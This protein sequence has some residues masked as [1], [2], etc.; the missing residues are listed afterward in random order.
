MVN[1][2]CIP[3]CQS[4]IHQAS[5]PTSQRFL[6]DSTTDLARP[7]AY[8]S[9]RLL[10]ALTFRSGR[11]SSVSALLLV[12]RKDVVRLLTD[13]IIVIVI[14]GIIRLLIGM[15]IC[16][17]FSASLIIFLFSPACQTLVPGRLPKKRILTALTIFGALKVPAMTTSS[18]V[19]F[20]LS[21]LIFRCVW[22]RSPCHCGSHSSETMRSRVSRHRSQNWDILQLLSGDK[23]VKDAEFGLHQVLSET[24]LPGIPTDV[25]LLTKV[26]VDLPLL[27][28]FDNLIRRVAANVSVLARRLLLLA[29]RL[30]AI[31]RAVWVV[32][33]L[34][35]LPLS[36]MVVL[37]CLRCFS[38]S[39]SSSLSIL[40]CQGNSRASACLRMFF[41][42]VLLNSLRGM[43]R[44]RSGYGGV[45][46]GGGGGSG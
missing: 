43:G 1:T 21:S 23:R 17:P 16:L 39:S 9:L 12:I 46:G 42:P 28:G 19:F 27:C 18:S 20:A 14:T 13:R 26:P 2:Y 40:R 45:G 36:Q 31:V 6:P 35:L 22:S 44:S 33:G 8:V 3:P 24:F 11:T 30:L 15:L 25:D 32:S 29:F 7:I 4:Q 37:R 5:E 41:F 38:A 34:A 10:P